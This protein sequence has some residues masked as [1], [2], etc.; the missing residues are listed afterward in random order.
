MHIRSLVIAF[1]AA[2]LLVSSSVRADGERD[3]LAT[4]PAPRNWLYFGFNGGISSVGVDDTINE[5]DKSGYQ[6]NLKLLGSRYWRDWVLDL[7][8]GYFYNQVS[9]DDLASTLQDAEVTVRTRAGFVELSPRYR[10]DENWQVGPVFNAL[11]G[12]DV[13]FDESETLNNK[14]FAF[15]IGPRLQYE[16]GDD[17]SRWRFGM[18]FM[19]DLNIANRSVM[20]VQAD[21][22][23]GIP[24]GNKSESPRAEEP[25][26]APSPTPTG[27]P[28]APQFAEVTSSNAVK[29][30][31]GEAVLR[32]RTAKS[33]LRPSSREIL[34]KVAKYLVKYSDAWGSMRVE[35]HA[36]KRGKLEYNNRLSRARAESVVG[37]L[38]KLGIPRKK[39]KAEGFG[40]SRP[41]DPEEDLE[42]YALNRRVEIWL[43]EVKDPYSISR[44]LNELR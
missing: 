9:G 12:T 30:Y 44:D 26:P 22:Q 43:D 38:A 17:S 23:Y 6:F 18:Q 24:F 28:Q 1:L 41:I 42:A 21:V 19:T 31:L 36:D 29:I 14:N 25:A 8:V 3:H 7:G 27:R 34:A 37:E 15:L 10:F 32:F 35:G 2:S 40:P 11:F 16:I 5:S 33:D 13:S 20:L 39:M 4:N